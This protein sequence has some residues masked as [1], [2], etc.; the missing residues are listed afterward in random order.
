MHTLV[1]K[2]LISVSFSR[3]GCRARCVHECYA[4]SI[5]ARAITLPNA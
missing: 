2:T 5:I 1:W 3:K 4:Y